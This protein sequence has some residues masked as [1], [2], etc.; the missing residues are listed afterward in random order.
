MANRVSLSRKSTL[1]EGSSEYQEVKKARS[2]KIGVNII[3]FPFLPEFCELVLMANVRIITFCD[4][5]FKYMQRKYSRQLYYK[6]ERVK[7]SK[8]E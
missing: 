5:I 3:G 7:K 6:H 8:W 4:V 2:A 1:K